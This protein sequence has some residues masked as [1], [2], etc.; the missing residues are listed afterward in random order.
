MPRRP[1]KQVAFSAAVGAL[2]AVLLLV[3]V[4]FVSPGGIRSLTI[5]SPA[6]VGVFGIALAAIA[7]A[8]F[9]LRSGPQ[10]TSHSRET[11]PA[12]ACPECGHTVISGWR[13]C[14]HCG[15]TNGSSGECGT[16]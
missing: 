14:P 15:V 16:P 10:G 8:A 11:R 2:T 5:A 7:V 4:S 13:L 1:Y 9:A 12:Q 6:G 3:V